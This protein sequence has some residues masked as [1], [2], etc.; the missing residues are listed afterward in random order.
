MNLTQ[1]LGSGRFKKSKRKGR[2][3][4]SG[5]GGTAG[6]GNKG[7]GQHAGKGLS[8]LYEGGQMP[9][10]RRLPKRGF[11]GGPFKKRFALVNVSA[12]NRF[13]SGETVDPEALV[14]SGVVRDLADGVKVLGDGELKS[15]LTVRAHKF[16]RSAREKIEAAGGSV[17][18]LEVPAYRIK[19]ELAA[20]AKAVKKEDE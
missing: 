7:F 1:V 12:L 10:F 13:S 17:E 11:S 8:V 19:R 2:G 16:S 4:G 5:K 15:K 6:R 18:V 20:R 9:L 3:P 14:A